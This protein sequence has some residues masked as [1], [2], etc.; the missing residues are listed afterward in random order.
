V[1]PVPLAQVLPHPQLI[2]PSKTWFLEFIWI[3]SGWSHLKSNISHILNPNLTKINSIKSC[4]SW[5]FQQHQRHIPILQL[6]F[7]LI[8]N[9]KSFNIQKLLHPKSKR[10]GTKPMHP[11]LSR[12]FERHQEHDLKHPNSMDLITTKQN[13]LP[14]FIDRQVWTV[15]LARV[16][17]C[18]Q[19]IFPSKTCFFEIYLNFQQQKNHLKINIFYIL[20]PNLTK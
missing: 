16:L 10:H 11:S 4:S 1:W 3:F 8:L 17:P 7:N 9:K 5:S 20:D 18:P 6:Q 15:P 14:S 19:L 13:K 12:A 2:F